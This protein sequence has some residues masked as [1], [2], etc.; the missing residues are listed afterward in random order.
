[1]NEMHSMPTFFFCANTRLAPAI[2]L[3]NSKGRATTA[4]TALSQEN[5]P[6][7]C[8][9]VASVIPLASF[10][11]AGQNLSGSEPVSGPV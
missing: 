3:L 5:H 2:R 4:A 8:I 10:D 1:M 6:K 7:E 11:I 9:G